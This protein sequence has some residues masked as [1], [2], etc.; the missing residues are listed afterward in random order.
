MPNDIGSLPILAA[1]VMAMAYSA[2]LIADPGSSNA[3]GRV[4]P[5]PLVH[6]TGGLERTL[7]TLAVKTGLECDDCSISEVLRI[8]SDLHRLQ[9]EIDKK[10]LAAAKISPDAPVTLSADETPLQSILNLSVAQGGVDWF[11]ADSGLTITSCS[12]AEEVHRRRLD[13]RL[14]YEIRIVDWVCELTPEQSRKLELACRGDILRLLERMQTR[15][16]Q[17]RLVEDD[18]KKAEALLA[19][20]EP[21]QRRIEMGPFE[22]G[23]FFRK[24][25][26]STLTAEQSSKYDPIRAVIDAGGQ[27]VTWQEG[28]ETLLGAILSNIPFT[29]DGV[30]RLKGLRAWKFLQLDGTQITDATVPHLEELTQLRL[31][32]LNGTMMTPQGASEL[33]TA[34]PNCRILGP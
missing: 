26:E 28:V 7:Q 8:L 18:P 11:V 21:L 10:A 30:K 2:N 19:E 6:S 5:P 33:K 12:A 24:T 17:L 14:D 15:K 16:S 25:L 27:V 4:L 13:E 32:L 29:D 23:T 3:P 1:V 9:I 31:L 22:K 34:L 20:L